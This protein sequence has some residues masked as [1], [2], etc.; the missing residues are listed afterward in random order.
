ESGESEN[1][2]TYAILRGQ[3]HRLAFV[4][5]QEQRRV[6][7]LGRTRQ[8]RM[9]ANAE[10]SVPLERVVDPHLPEHA[11]SFF[12][13]VLRSCRIDTAQRGFLKRGAAAGAEIQ[14]APGEVV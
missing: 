3:C 14:P 13:L 8:D 11:Q 10:R 6:G 2:R 12:D 7:Q 5:R 4:A 9:R 1:E